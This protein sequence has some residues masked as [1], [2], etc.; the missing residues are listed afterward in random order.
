MIAHERTEE[1]A[2]ELVADRLVQAHLAGRTDVMD[3]V[4]AGAVLDDESET[5][6]G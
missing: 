5:T 3:A 4:Q 1:Q 2:R 6:G